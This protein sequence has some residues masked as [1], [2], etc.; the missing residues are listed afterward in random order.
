MTTQSANSSNSGGSLSL[1]LG[2]GV[3]APLGLASIGFLAFLL[4]RNRRQ[5][6][7]S[8]PDDGLTRMRA[9]NPAVNLDLGLKETSDGEI[10]QEMSAKNIR[11][12]P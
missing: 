9:Q 12:I 5:K 3:E 11:Q 6:Q 7:A 10:V 8:T 2:A 1:A 4:R